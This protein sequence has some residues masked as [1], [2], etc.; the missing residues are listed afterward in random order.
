MIPR[1]Q[2]A[3]KATWV[4]PMSTTRNLT[5]WLPETISVLCPRR[6]MVDPHSAI[7]TEKE[8]KFLMSDS[9]FTT[10]PV[11]DFLDQGPLFHWFGDIPR[12]AD[13]SGH[14]TMF[15]T[16]PCGHHENGS[17]MRLGSRTQRLNH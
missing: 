17:R 10:R 7:Q 3:G 16:R 12:C 8:E 9:G 2:W 14:L 6:P 1:T 15:F 4:G 11:L 13:T 5:V